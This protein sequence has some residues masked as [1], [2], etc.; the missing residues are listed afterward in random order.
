MVSIR[1]ACAEARRRAHTSHAGAVLALLAAD[2][3]FR[4][5]CRYVMALA[6]ANRVLRNRRT[7]I[8]KDYR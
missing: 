4:H 2:V 3:A 6:R 7:H 1:E 5:A 8:M